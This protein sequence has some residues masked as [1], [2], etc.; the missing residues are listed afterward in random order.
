MKWRIYSTLLPSSRFT[1]IAQTLYTHNTHTNE[2]NAT[3]H[4]VST[5]NYT[6]S[7]M[8]I[9]KLSIPN[10]CSHLPVKK[11]WTVKISMLCAISWPPSNFPKI[12]QYT[13]NMRR[14][15]DIFTLIKNK[16]THTYRADGSQPQE[17]ANKQIHINQKHYYTH[18]NTHQAHLISVNI[19][20]KT[21]WTSIGLR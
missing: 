18:T 2:P 3:S 13:R 12:V 17:Q 7:Y 9:S 11:V 4:I 21:L 10:T 1:N 20:T 8:H 16:N 5:N 19:Q 15:Y 6:H 14:E